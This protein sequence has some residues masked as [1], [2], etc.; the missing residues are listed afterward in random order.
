M[1]NCQ[2]SPVLGVGEKRILFVHRSLITKNT[3]HPLLLIWTVLRGVDNSNSCVLS[4]C[5][6]V[7]GCGWLW[8]ALSWRIG[9]IILV[10]WA[11]RN[12]LANSASAADEA[13]SLMTVL[14][15]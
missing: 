9:L 15:T 12:N 1:D 8:V 11:L 2:G 6:G 14:S 13:T 3:F 7:G 10:C 4:M 5:I